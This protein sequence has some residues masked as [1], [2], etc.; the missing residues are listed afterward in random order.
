MC[1]KLAALRTI[2]RCL[3]VLNL[4][5]HTLLSSFAE[6]ILIND[7]SFVLTA[8]QIAANNQQWKKTYSTIRMFTK[9]K[10]LKN[11]IKSTK[12]CNDIS[13]FAM[14]RSRKCLGYSTDDP[15]F[16]KCTRKIMLSELNIVHSHTLHTVIQQLH[17]FFHSGGFLYT[18][19]IDTD[20]SYC[21]GSH[22]I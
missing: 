21:M 7:S 4:F 12:L 13:F 17:Q 8:R 14:G 15:F 11:L 10:Q 16:Q 5:K 3:Y 18:K 9:M 19:Y 1:E 22:Q 20:K 6:R 2:F